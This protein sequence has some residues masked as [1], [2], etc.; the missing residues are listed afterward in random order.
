[1]NFHPIISKLFSASIIIVC[2]YFVLAANPFVIGDRQRPDSGLRVDRELPKFRIRNDENVFIAES[3]LQD[4]KYLIY[5]AYG[6]CM[7]V[8]R[9][10]LSKLNTLLSKEEYKSWNLVLISLAP[11][12]DRKNRSWM[13][14]YLSHWKRRPI[15]LLPEDRQEAEKIAGLFQ[16]GVNKGL[17]EEILHRNP[18]FITD[19]KGRIRIVY[20]DLTAFSE[21]SFRNL[22]VKVY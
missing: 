1:M 13:R 16:V 3:D 20:P 15:L 6:D 4:R 9:T 22:E 5:F 11:K 2:L 12:E 19:N 18:L 21:E 14:N 10:G 17:N 8:C 7:S